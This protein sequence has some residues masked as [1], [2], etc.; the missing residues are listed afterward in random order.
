MFLEKSYKANIDTATSGDNTIIAAPGAGKY[1]AIDHINMVPK[2]GVTIQFKDGSTDYGGDYLLT[3]SQGFVLENVY[4]DQ[5]GIITCSDNSAFVINL[6][7]NV[8]V[9]GFVRY[10]ILP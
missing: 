8:Q 7:G 9:S 10:R 5:D 3:T 2:G 4:A 1:L 6:S